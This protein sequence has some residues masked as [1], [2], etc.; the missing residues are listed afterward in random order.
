MKFIKEII[1]YILIK[2]IRFFGISSEKL[3][4]PKRAI[5][6]YEWE[7][8]S[9]KTYSSNYLEIIPTQN[10]TEKQPNSINNEINWRFLSLQKRK[11]PPAFVLKI[12]KGR[13]LGTNGVIISESDEII[14]DISREFSQTKFQ[15]LNKIK[16][17]KLNFLK[18]N[19]AVLTT[20]GHNVYYHW[21]FDILPRIYLLKEA[22]IFD[23]IDNF[24]L[25]EIKYKFQKETL[26]LLN[27][28][29][30]KIIEIKNNQQIKSDFLFVPAL[31]SL[32]GTVNKWAV[33]FL[34][35]Q[36]LKS[37]NTTGKKNLYLTR[38]DAIGRNIK[39]EK[40]LLEL[41]T[42]LDFEVIDP[43]D[44]SFTE[45]VNLFSE[46]K[47]IIAPHG[48]ALSNIA[49]CNE[50]CTVVDIMPPSF[51]IPVFWILSNKVGLKYYYFIGEGQKQ[52]EYT[53]YWH[54][55]NSDILIDIN[56]FEI[57]LKKILK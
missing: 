56:K 45:Q 30:E 49:F 31:P 50:N 9:Y 52:N 26:E 48:S 54:S 38:K 17:G 21:L 11:Q 57:F 16:L 39:N 32:L 22:N 3:G 36:F 19:T 28:P 35:N 47:Y 7:K 4:S 25:P 5:S 29:K 23:R 37:Q 55:K 12:L 40:Q 44:F 20:A 10:I 18:G 15:S 24:I 42:P 8:T 33:D 2:T 34:R 46:A 53:D 41:L 6:L 14:I 51:I 13:V 43:A 27:F 1:K